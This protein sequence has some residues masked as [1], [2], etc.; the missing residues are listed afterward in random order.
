LPEKVLAV[1]RF[2]SEEKQFFSVLVSITA[3][4]ASEID[5]VFGPYKN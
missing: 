4:I 2:W 1:L 5:V 3:I